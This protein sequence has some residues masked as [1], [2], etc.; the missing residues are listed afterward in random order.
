MRSIR[1]RFG[2]LSAQRRI[3]LKCLFVF[4]ADAAIFLAIG[5]GVAWSMVTAIACAIGARI[6]WAIREER[7]QMRRESQAT[8]R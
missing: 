1:E 3:A 2:N 5:Y 4:V 6:G 7:E 8:P